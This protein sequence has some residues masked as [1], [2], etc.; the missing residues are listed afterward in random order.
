M[1]KSLSQKLYDRTLKLMKWTC[2]AEDALTRR[3]ALK[4]L[5][6]VAKHSRKLAQLQGQAYIESTQEDTP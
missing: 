6:K 5:R 4:A 3:Q 2:R 1:S